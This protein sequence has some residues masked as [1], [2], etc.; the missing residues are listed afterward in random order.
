MLQQT[1]SHFTASL[2]DA[3]R[4][5]SHGWRFLSITVSQCSWYSFRPDMQIVRHCPGIYL[6]GKSTWRPERTSNLWQRF[7]P[8]TSRLI[9]KIASHYGAARRCLTLQTSIEIDSMFP[10]L[11][12][13]VVLQCWSSFI[14]M[15]NSRKKWSWL[16]LLE[17]KIYCHSPGETENNHEVTR[18]GCL[19]F[20]QIRN[21]HHRN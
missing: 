15:T 18:L 19:M 11:L 20:G 2:S 8:E 1:V 16:S 3:V 21:E 6:I 13:V 10:V 17:S 14:Q 12:Y 4:Y 5:S 9:N 7:E